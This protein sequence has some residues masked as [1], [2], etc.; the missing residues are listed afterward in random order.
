[1]EQ[2]KIDQQAIVP[3]DFENEGLSRNLKLFRPAVFKDGD[4]YC[5]LL[6]PDPTTGIFGCGSSAEAAMLD[7]DNHLNDF[8]RSHDPD[9]PLAEYVLATLTASP[10][11]I[12]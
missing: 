3:V 2:M 5:A 7:W 9:D 8:V 12:L 11:N 6:G 4:S 10:N 1:M